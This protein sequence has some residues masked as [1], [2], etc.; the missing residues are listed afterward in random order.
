MISTVKSALIRA[1]DIRSI[2]EREAPLPWVR[3]AHLSESSAVICQAGNSRPS[4]VLISTYSGSRPACSG[5]SQTSRVR[6]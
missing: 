1:R 2:S 3:I 4:G 5:E 6:P